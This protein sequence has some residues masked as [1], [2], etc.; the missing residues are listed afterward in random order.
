MSP[1][2]LDEKGAIV[3]WHVVDLGHLVESSLAIIWDMETG[4][5][6]V[7]PGN[8]GFDGRNCLKMADGSLDSNILLVNTMSKKFASLL[9]NILNARQEISRVQ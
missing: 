7:H 8:G 4:D 3:E 1:N 5:L 2:C 9:Q 6:F